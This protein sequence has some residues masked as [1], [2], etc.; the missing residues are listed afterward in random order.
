MKSTDSQFNGAWSSS[1]LLLLLRLCILKPHAPY[2]SRLL[3]HYTVFTVFLLYSS[4]SYSNLLQFPL[5]DLIFGSRSFRAAAPTTVLGTPF[6]ARSVRLIHSTLRRYLK[7]QLSKQLLI[8]YSGSACNSFMWLLV[9]Y[10]RFYLLSWYLLTYLPPYRSHFDGCICTDADV[11]MEQ[12]ANSRRFMRFGRQQ[13]QQQQQT[14]DDV[15]QIVVEPSHPAKR[16][17]MRFGR[18]LRRQ[19]LSGRSWSC[20]RRT[21]DAWRCRPKDYA[22]AC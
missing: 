14:P 11:D 22:N 3:I 10:N 15:S 19:Q 17:F 18:G 20:H 8:L 5:T 6:L 12:Q 7:T 9:R 1:L 16:E 21:N 4:S 2:L 13:H